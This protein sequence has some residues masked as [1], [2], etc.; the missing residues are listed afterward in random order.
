M[1]YRVIALK[2][3]LDEMPLV[4]KTMREIHGLSVH[5][6]GFKIGKRP[7]T[8]YAYERGDRK[9]PTEVIEAIAELYNLEVH[10]QF[11]RKNVEKD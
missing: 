9:I 11:R 8:I 3:K 10:Y 7:S 1:S 4:F 6:L 2:V 5:Q